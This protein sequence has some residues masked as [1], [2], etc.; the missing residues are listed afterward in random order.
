MKK[1]ILKKKLAIQTEHVS[2]F[3]SII[4]AKDQKIDELIAENNNNKEI[5]EQM[6]SKILQLNNNITEQ[7][8]YIAQLKRNMKG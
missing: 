3:L 8:I 7:E 5:I 2:N 6:R 4:H 1:K